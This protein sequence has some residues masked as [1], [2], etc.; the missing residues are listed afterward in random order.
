VKIWF[1]AALGIRGDEVCTGWAIGEDGP[2]KLSLISAVIT[3]KAHRKQWSICRVIDIEGVL[4]L[5][6]TSLALRIA[7]DLGGDLTI[8]HI[9]M[10]IPLSFTI[11]D[12]HHCLSL[13][14]T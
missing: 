10:E 1:H 14:S 6:L 3:L 8:V 11:L 2:A 7:R 9:E 13:A 4:F 12:R 5:V